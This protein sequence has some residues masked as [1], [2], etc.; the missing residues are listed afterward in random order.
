MIAD[1]LK[2]STK[3]DIKSLIG[4]NEKYLII[5][6]LFEGNMQ[7]YNE[8]I[9][10]LNSFH[11]KGEAQEHINRINKQKQWKEGLESLNKLGEL[12]ENG[13]PS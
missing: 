4:I 5:N 6:E 13:Y 11:S 12:I 9:T 3:G 2:S 8:F 7:E 10:T 1:K